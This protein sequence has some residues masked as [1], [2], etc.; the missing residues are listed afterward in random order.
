VSALT[1]GLA[2]TLL[3]CGRISFDPDDDLTTDDPLVDAPAGPA[4]AACTPG[5]FGPPVRLSSISSDVAFEWGG[6]ISDDGLTVMFGSDAGGDFDIYQATRASEADDFGPARS[7]GA[8]NTSKTEDNP[9][10]SA[11]GLTLWFD[12][13]L[14]EHV[15]VRA[16]L[17]DDFDAD[18]PAMESPDPDLFAIEFSADR[19]TLI[20]SSNRFAGPDG[21][22]LFVAHRAGAALSFPAVTL[23]TDLDDDGF[24]CC[25]TLSPDGQLLAY[26]TTSLVEGDFSLALAERAGDTFTNR[27]AFE[28]VPHVPGSDDNDPSWSKSGRF[29]L[30]SSNRAGSYDLY[31]MTAACP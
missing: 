7:V 23:L 13:D 4:D 24:N 27:T 30:F 25:G 11:D 8:I 19:L 14:V 2:A 9:L 1:L 5:R 16:S 6:F 17:A 29:F 20:A 18:V 12:R 10:L 15:A 22:D 28:P 26:T 21:S 31:L 3:G